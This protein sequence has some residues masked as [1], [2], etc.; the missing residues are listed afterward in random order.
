M[1]FKSL[2]RRVLWN[3]VW[4]LGYGILTLRVRSLD[5]ETP[6]AG[7]LHYLIDTMHC[8]PCSRVF[9]CRSIR[10]S[11]TQF[12]ACYTASRRMCLCGE[13]L[14]G[15][16]GALSPF[17]LMCNCRCVISPYRDGDIEASWQHD[18]DGVRLAVASVLRLARTTLSRYRSSLDGRASV[19]IAPMTFT[20]EQAT[21]AR[22][23]RH[24]VPAPMVFL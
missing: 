4:P 3:G 16:G 22:I 19:R 5:L 8:F 10:L 9:Q 23:V 24:A 7:S 21:P 2:D 13:V 15:R 17:G 1:S 20:N 12:P 14:F 6:C 18:H 11:K